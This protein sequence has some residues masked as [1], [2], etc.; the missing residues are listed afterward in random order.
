MLVHYTVP[1]C[2]N[3]SSVNNF[4]YHDGV[5][6][7]KDCANCV[8]EGDFEYTEISVEKEKSVL[9]H[10]EFAGTYKRIAHLNERLSQGVLM[11]PEIPQSDMDLIRE[12]FES[13]GRQYFKKQR[14]DCNAITKKD[15]QDTLR[16]LDNKNKTNFTVKY[17]EKWKSIIFNLTGE[18]PQ[19][20][21]ET[22]INKIGSMFLM[23]SDK[24]NEWQPPKSKYNRDNWRFPERKHFPNFNFIIRKCA[25]LQGI[26]Y[27]PNDWPIPT[28]SRCVDRLNFYFEEMCKELKINLNKKNINQ[29]KLDDF[30]DISVKQNTPKSNTNNNKLKYNQM[31]I[32]K[33][34]KPRK[35][36]KKN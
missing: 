29:K 14:F 3:C 8:D 25:D 1:K 4:A 21:T 12:E 26:E 27:D 23:F 33:W 24:W 22:E 30:M 6:V 11:E 32:E 5:H 7:C 19:I 35:K 13:L 28:T 36:I 15:I 20:W 9:Y 2:P 16:S 17:L 31:S 18:F 34:L 10:D